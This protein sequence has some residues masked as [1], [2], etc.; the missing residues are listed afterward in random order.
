MSHTLGALP[1]IA[2]TANTLR[3][4]GRAMLAAAPWSLAV[5]V[6][7]LPFAILAASLYWI[8]GGVFLLLALVNLIAF[9]RMTFAWHRVIA[10]EGARAEAVQ[11][12]TPQ[13]W[14]LLMLGGLVIVVAALARATG[15]LPYVLYVVL[16]APPTALFFAALILVVLAIWLPVLY[17]LATLAPALARAA[18]TG[19]AGFRGLRGE[20]VYPRWPLMLALGMLVSAGGLAHN[21]LFE[22]LG[23]A[24]REGLAW[25]AVY[26]ALFIVLTFVAGIV[27]SV[28]YRVRN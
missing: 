3:R 19:V 2:A 7:S 16:D 27:V 26:L 21:K 17:A 4:D 14:H 6:L 11:G 23:Y 24:T 18:V 25:V 28:A 20:A 10:G 15:D 13:A 22:Y 12:G 8:Q 9:S 5:F 1:F